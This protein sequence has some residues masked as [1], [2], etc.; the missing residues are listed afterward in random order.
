MIELNEGIILSKGAPKEPVSFLLDKGQVNII[1]L[2]E[3]YKFSF[4]RLK[5]QSLDKGTF[6]IDGTTIYPNEENGKALFF[7]QVN[8]LIK[9]GLCF[10]CD[11][12]NKKQKVKEVQ[13]GLITLRELKTDTDEEKNAKIAAIFAKICE[14][15]PSYVIFDLNDEGNK[16]NE[17]LS[18]EIA[19]LAKDILVIAL[20]QK[21]E[22]VKE[23]IEEAKVQEKELVSEPEEIEAE[24][25]SL[26]I[27][28]ETRETRIRTKEQEVETEDFIVFDTKDKNFLTAF[29]KT[30]KNNVMVFLSFVIPTTGIIAF[31]LLSPLYFQ[32]D[33][34]VLL[35]PFIITIVICFVLYVIMTYKCTSFYINRKDPHFKKKMGIFNIGNVLVTLIGIGL[36]VVIYILFKN[37]DAELKKI[38]TTNTLG[39]VLSIVFSV[40]LVTENLYMTI[41]INKIKLLFK[42][43]K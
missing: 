16:N 26:D 32:S 39:I 31:L 25:Y 34:K 5:D 23:E 13:D 30:F 21:I 40:I 3:K 22:V 10:V 4:L 43:K 12:E 2:G 19:V 7:L 18:N 37:F 15:S 35:I 42:K 9:L 24:E 33:N 11:K 14:F 1:P 8:S 6:K 20:E 41:V 29:F 27:G 36:G 38:T 17:Y 28:E